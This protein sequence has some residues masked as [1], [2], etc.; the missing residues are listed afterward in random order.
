MSAR[1]LVAPSKTRFYRGAIAFAVAFFLFDLS[2][3]LFRFG[4]EHVT[5]WW[6]DLND[7]PMTL[8]SSTMCI[9]AARRHTGRT[10]RAWILLAAGMTSWGLGEA[11]WSYYELGLHKQPFPSLA[12]AG[13]LMLI[14]FM[15]FALLSLPMAPRNAVARGRVFLDGMII[16]TSL[17]GLSW[18]TTLGAVF[19]KGGN[20]ILENV[21]SLAYPFGDIVLIGLV[22][23]VGSRAARLSRSSIGFIGAGILSISISDSLFTYFTYKN[24][25]GSDMASDLVGL[26]WMAGWLLIGLGALRSEAKAVPVEDTATKRWGVF[27]P[28]VGVV[29]ALP[30]MAIRLFLD[31]TKAHPVTLTALIVLFI[32]VALRQV[33]TVLEN[34]KLAGQ[35]EVK[36]AERTKDLEVALEKLQAAMDAQER[37]HAAQRE[38]VRIAAHE[39]QTPTVPIATFAAMLLERWETTP[40]A[41]KLQQLEVIDRQARRLRRLTTMMAGISRIDDGNVDINPDEVDVGSE[42][43]RLIEETNKRKVPILF[44]CDHETRVFAD[45]DYFRS[46][47]AH[48]LENAFIHGGPPVHVTVTAEGST[49]A[50]RVADGGAGV[51]D[52]F[53]PRLF[54]KFAQAKIDSNAS[55]SGVGVGLYSVR[56]IARA[57]GGDAWYETTADGHAFGLRLPTFTTSRPTTVLKRAS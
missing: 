39:L 6:S 17:F 21:L 44:E 56:E 43:V 8:L 9:L 38:F 2:W 15:A 3:Y 14:P 46:M 11:V 26:G 23:F 47:V 19:A 41:I 20:S 52:E 25:F 32:V 55:S 22:L 36:V 10:K 37:M 7:I 50:I 31:K 35:L 51:P 27:M 5:H 45:P 29:V 4:G 18:A 57:H 28:Y 34:R 40:D 13:Y 42:I 33:L 16:A 30:T 12:D 1:S 48:L 54:D 53:L 49:V 24:A